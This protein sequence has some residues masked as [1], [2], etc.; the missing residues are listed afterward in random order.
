M[1]L[2]AFNQSVAKAGM[3]RSPV[4]DEYTSSPAGGLEWQKQ[5][6]GPNLTCDEEIMEVIEGNPSQEGWIS[7]RKCRILEFYFQ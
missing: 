5:M 4:P 3:F 7:V 1:P 6:R 2:R